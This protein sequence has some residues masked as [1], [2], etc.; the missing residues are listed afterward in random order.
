VKVGMGE[1]GGVLQDRSQGVRFSSGLCLA[2]RRP[3][4]PKGIGVFIMETEDQRWMR[5]ALELAEKGRGRTSPNPMVGAVLVKE[6]R[7][8]GEGF[9]QRAGGPHA[10]VNA[11][12]EAGREAAGSTMYVTLEP[13]T[14]QGRTP[15]CVDSLLE[16]GLGRV[17]VGMLDVNPKVA[18]RGIGRLEEAGL[19]VEVGLFEQ[20]CRRL[21]EAYITWM[22][23]KRPFVVLKVA[24]SL[25]GKIATYRGQSRWISGEESRKRV[26]ALRACVDAV[27]VGAATAVADDPELTVRMV[28]GDVRQPVRVVV[29]STLRLPATA[30]LLA[31]GSE[32]KTVVATTAKAPQERRRAVEAMG[33]D[34]LVLPERQG[35][36]DL[37]SLMARLAEMDV[38]SLLLEG[39]GELNASMVEEGLVDKVLVI[40]APM[41]LGGGEAPTVLDGLGVGSIEE[42]WRLNE[43]SFQKVGE[44]LHVEG[45]LER[46]A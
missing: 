4:A 20:E 36:V 11:L 24:S 42:A 21:N 33:R 43:L 14:H 23:E 39:G 6:G 29:D 41:L 5:R 30:R 18:G 9:H 22:M 2:L 38:V 19:P 17:V 13:C 3:G 12:R 46:G 27:M 10:E 26:H 35:R 1:G 8:V 7:A 15:P 16:V 32:L 45:Y 28:E 40:I 34:V 25:D 31:E 37:S 44:D